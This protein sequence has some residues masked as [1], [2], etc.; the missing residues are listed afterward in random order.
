ML[1]Q[2]L[3]VHLGEKRLQAF[4]SVGAEDLTVEELV[5][6]PI[7]G[8]S[9]STDSSQWLTKA[10][11]TGLQQARDR[12][13]RRYPPFG[14]TMLAKS[15]EGRLKI[16]AAD[17]LSANVVIPDS[18]QDPI[19]VYI[20]HVAL[21]VA[22][23]ERKGARSLGSDWDVPGVYVLLDPAAPGGT[24]GGY[25]GKA[26][27][28][29][30]SRL[31]THLSQKDH[32][33]RAVLVRRDTKYGFHSA[34][35]GWLEGRLYDLL[36]AAANARLHN[37]RRPVDETLPPHD[38]QMLESCVMPF[39]RVLRLL[40]Y[41][42]TPTATS[43]KNEL[44]VPAARTSTSKP[45][46]RVIRGTVQDLLRAGL[47][48]AHAKLVSTSRAWPAEATVLPDGRIEYGGRSFN[49]PSGA[50]DYV[51]SGSVNGWS[52]WATETESGRV[53]LGALRARL[54]SPSRE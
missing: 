52:F 4:A 39:V 40:G 6:P 28:G 31:S 24:W 54:D 13:Q 12:T 5:Q 22:I 47:L 45:A 41:D 33:S 3:A 30:K 10:G 7:S 53:T 20:D 26:P 14:R 38:R 2:M 23:V 19:E 11:R 49:S 44:T 43:G 42:P 1:A 48:Q 51:T 16:G 8:F 50:A 32:W 15:L 36:H 37:I 34:Q 35:V 17:S 21:C 29:I 18:A 25:V 46:R 27:A 9:R